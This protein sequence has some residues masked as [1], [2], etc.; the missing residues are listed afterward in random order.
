MNYKRL[1]GSTLKIIA[2]LSMLLDH[3]GTIL[4]KNG[5]VMNAPYSLFSDDQFVKLL[6]VIE[7]CHIL[8]R[9]AF[10]LFCFL[11][12]EGFIHTH[13]VR[14][15]LLNLGIFAVISEAIYDWSLTG[16]V[17]N[18]AQ[19][20]VLL[21][22]LLGLITI[23]LIRKCHDNLFAALILTGASAYLSY[24]LHLDGWYYGIALIVVFYIFR[25][26]KTGKLLLAIVVMYLCGLDYTLQ[27]LLDPY[28]L[29]SAFSVLL[30][31]MYNG[32]R[33]LRLKYFFYAFYPGHLLILAV[34]TNFIVIPMIK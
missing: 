30:M 8:G 25:Q 17:F 32:A 20:N 34:L 22:L 2:V 16:K 31:A 19:Q 5:I 21:T 29:A 23:M 12:V 1:S 11:L 24:V 18:P 9:I 33:G 27:A 13:S 26:Q 28:F 10:P 6:K 15:Y 4:L 7:L 14:K 3:V